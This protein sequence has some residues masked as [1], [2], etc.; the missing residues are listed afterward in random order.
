VNRKAALAV[1]A[2]ALL[3][4]GVLVTVVRR[5]NSDAAAID[6]EVIA[7]S[8]PIVIPDLCRTLVEV[9]A[10]ERTAAYNSFYDK[11]HPALHVLAA[12]VDRRGESG[13]AT[14]TRLRRAK[15]KVEAEI[16]TFP[17]TLQSDLTA[18]IVV[19][20]EALSQVGFAGETSC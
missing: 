18:L 14:G 11:A 20:G 9:A 4:I 5:S 2:V 10:G 15:S 3:C 1:L 6:P 13:R 12:D 19:T 17:T 16:I 7:I 8:Y